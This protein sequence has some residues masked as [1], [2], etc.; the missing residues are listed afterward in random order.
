MN[1]KIATYTPELTEA[2]VTEYQAGQTVEQIAATHGRSTRSIIAKL[3]QLKV[4]HTKAPKAPADRITKAGLVGELA[5]MLELA[6]MHIESLE[7]ADKVALFDVVHAVRR[8]LDR[9]TEART[10]S[11]GSL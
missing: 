2:I 11:D 10:V 7:K 6:P 1:S 4:Y 9:A 3:A 5:Q 8:V